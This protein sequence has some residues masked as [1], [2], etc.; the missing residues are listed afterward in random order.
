[1]NDD[2]VGD[3]LRG[4]A[5][6]RQLVG[7]AQPL[8]LDRR[9][10]RRRLRDDEGD[11]GRPLGDQRR[12]PAALAHAVEADAAGVDL[13]AAPAAAAAPRG[14]RRPGRR[15]SP[16]TS[17][18]STRR[19]PRLSWISTAMPA[20]AYMSA[21]G[22]SASRVERAR[23]VDHHHGGMRPGAGWAAAACPP[24][25]TPPL[26]E[27]DRLG[28]V[29]M[30]AHAQR[31]VPSAPRPLDAVDRRR[32][33]PPAPRSSARWDSRSRATARRPSVR[34]SRANSA[35]TRPRSWST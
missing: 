12:D 2:G 13:R 4:E 1:M 16:P 26:L 14:H 32:P 31:R 33:A 34:S 5:V 3:Q 10:R 24:G 22:H 7:H 21:H 9:H 35:P 6:R 29:R 23:A 27:A 15:T 28:A 11:V 19:C 20:R 30:A 8:V 17:S 25:W 18:R